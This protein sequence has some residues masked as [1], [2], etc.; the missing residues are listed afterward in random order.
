MF[1]KNKPVKFSAGTS[2]MFGNINKDLNVYE[3]VCFSIWRNG[4]SDLRFSRLKDT[5]I[6]IAPV[7]GETRF[8]TSHSS[9]S[10]YYLGEE[11]IDDKGNTKMVLVVI[12]LKDLQYK[13]YDLANTGEK[14]KNLRNSSL[15]MNDTAL[16]F[17]RTAIV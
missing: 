16:C 3:Y 12:S 5:V 2:K 9:K 17:Q 14:L 7:Q 11:P 13:T 1:G 4:G 15:I 10:V 8:R 6:P